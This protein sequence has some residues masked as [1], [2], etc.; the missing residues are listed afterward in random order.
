MKLLVTGASG[1]VGWEL[2]RS[3]MPLGEVVAVG[4]AECNLAQ[5]QNI[6]SLLER[7]RPD[8]IVNAAAYTAVDKAEADEQQATFVNGTA[9][10][11]LAEWAK[12]SNALLV[13]Y[14]TDYVFDGNKATAYTEADEPCPVSAYGRSKL[15]GELAI[16]QSG[17]DHLILRTSWVFASRGR[18]FVRTMLRLAQERQELSVV[19]DQ[20]GAP[21][22]ARNIADATAHI[23]RQAQ[24][25]R[26]QACFASGIFNLTSAGETSWHGFT[27]AILDGAAERGLLSAERLP[28][29]RPIPTEAYPLPAPRPKNSRLAGGRLRERFGVALP[30]WQNA[31]ARCLDEF[32]KP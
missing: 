7:V 13:H 10:G 19:D 27:R 16:G 23:I 25:E 12:K 18:N 21:T 30:D 1:Q 17:C 14:S 26:Q 20:I 2:A 8:V 22:W 6:Q 29:L 3:L 24:K 28:Q 9:A 31:L 5:P 4:S 32:P 11:V 15:A